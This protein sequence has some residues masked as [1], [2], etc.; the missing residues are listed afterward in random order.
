MCLHSKYLSSS[1]RES[2]VTHVWLSVLSVRPDKNMTYLLFLHTFT[3]SS[4][5]LSLFRWSVISAEQL[6][7]S[8]EEEVHHTMWQF[9]SSQTSTRK[10]VRGLNTSSDESDWSRWVFTNKLQ[11]LLSFLYS[12]Q[13]IY[14]KPIRQ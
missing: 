5:S 9:T 11:L 14:I 3:S 7:V 4:L 6:S 2:C 12:C 1:L 10:T 13:D 8:K